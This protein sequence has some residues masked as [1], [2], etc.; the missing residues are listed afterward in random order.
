M[1][2]K[3]SDLIYNGVEHIKCQTKEYWIEKFESVGLTR[4]LELEENLMTYICSGYHMGWFR[5]N[6]VVFKKLINN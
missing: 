4:D 3:N 1:G 2:I 5:M 6:G